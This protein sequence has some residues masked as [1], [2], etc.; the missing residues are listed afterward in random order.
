MPLAKDSS[1]LYVQA[2][3]F[4]KLDRART[5]RDDLADLGILDIL[6]V[7]IG[8]DTFYRV[9][10]GPFDDVENASRVRAAVAARGL[11][12]ARIFAR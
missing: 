7:E 2:A 10:L 8:T 9:R 4:R 3:S 11:A 1:G 5:L 12:G 6:P